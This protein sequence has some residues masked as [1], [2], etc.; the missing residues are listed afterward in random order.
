MSTPQFRLPRSIYEAL[1]YLYALGGTLLAVT[2]FQLTNAWLSGLLVF[3]GLAA[4][5]CGSAIWLRRRD[6]RSS[7]RGY[8]GFDQL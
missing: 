8:E 2:G 1:P 7:Q 5:V 3:A 6:Y 4:L